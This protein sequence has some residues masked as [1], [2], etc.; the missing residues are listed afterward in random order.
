MSMSKVD[1]N[2]AFRIV[3]SSEYL[4]IPCDEES[5]DYTFSKS[6]IKKMNKLIKLQSRGYYFLLNTAA[7]RAAAVL[8]VFLALC[9]VSMSVSAIRQPIVNLFFEIRS[10]FNE[11][12]VEGDTVIIIE[13]RY[14]ITE[15]PAGYIQ[16][17][18]MDT[19]ISRFIVYENQSGDEIEFSQ[20]ISDGAVFH[21]DNEHCKQETIYIDDLK[22]DLY[23]WEWLKQVIWVEDC[24]VFCIN[25]SDVNF[26]VEDIKKVIM[27]VK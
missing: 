20:I 21:I 22:I 1:F 10:G 4:Q 18:I 2:N 14:S 23:E 25:F 27:S 26:S 19:D 12:Y 15:L 9:T 8:I 3:I 7:K 13:K 5:I 11:Y 16:K 17:D 6:F 24:Y